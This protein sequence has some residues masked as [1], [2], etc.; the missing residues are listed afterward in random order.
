VFSQFTSFTLKLRNIIMHK[1][2]CP[3]LSKTTQKPL[4]LNFQA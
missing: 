2:E 1:I 4:L 3:H